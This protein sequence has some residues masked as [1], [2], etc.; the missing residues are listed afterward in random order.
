M[1]PV[2]APKFALPKENEVPEPDP[3][4]KV[5]SRAEMWS[6]ADAGRAK[7]ALREKISLNGLWAITTDGVNNLASAP[8]VDKMEYF[9]KVPGEWPSDNKYAR[10]GMAVWTAKGGDAFGTKVRNFESLYGKRADK[11]RKLYNG[12]I[13][14]QLYMYFK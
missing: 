7:T 14:C 4:A 9:F 12:M 2:R 5:P 1:K 10:Q 8:A 13:K 3:L 6:F 11:T